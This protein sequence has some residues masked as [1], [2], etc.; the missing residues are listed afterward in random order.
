MSIWALIGAL[1]LQAPAASAQA[2]TAPVKLPPTYI[3]GVQKCLSDLPQPSGKLY[4]NLAELGRG[5]EADAAVERMIANLA[6]SYKECLIALQNGVNDVV[7]KN[8][9]QL[10]QVR[11]T[12]ADVQARRTNAT[13]TARSIIEFS[14]DEFAEQPARYW[15]TLSLGSD[16]DWLGHDPDPF[17]T[18]VGKCGTFSIGEARLDRYRPA[19]T[20]ATL[21]RMYAYRDCVDP[22]SDEVYDASQAVDKRLRI[23]KIVAFYAPYV[24]GTAPP[25]H[26]VDRAQWQALSN[27]LTPARIAKLTAMAARIAPQLDAALKADEEM[28]GYVERTEATIKRWNESVGK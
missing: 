27:K 25:N 8:D 12:R 13:K 10:Q 21:K 18:L 3:A 5:P 16:I 2:P 22:Y 28:T 14:R 23:A 17:P 20:N 7:P 11:V 19:I 6:D 26:C 24:C 9:F 4:S 1:V 15:A